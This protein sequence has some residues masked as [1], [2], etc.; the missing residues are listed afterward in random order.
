MC[1]THIDFTAGKVIYQNYSRMLDTMCINKAARPSFNSVVLLCLPLR[2]HIHSLIYRQVS[3]VSDFS[4]VLPAYPL[5]LSRKTHVDL[6]PPVS[7]TV[8]IKQNV[9]RNKMAGKCLRLMPHSTL[10][11]AN[12]RQRKLN[13]D[14]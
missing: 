11:Y 1:A 2:L 9:E 5:T 3:Q 7:R 8:E 13:V 4:P 14:T 10:Q 6:L 12:D